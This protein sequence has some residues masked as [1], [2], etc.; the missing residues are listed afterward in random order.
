MV[1]YNVARVADDAGDHVLDLG[2]SPGAW[3]QVAC[4]HL[5]PSRAGGCVTGLDIKVHAACL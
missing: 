4:R 1:K 3:L 2:C 5:G